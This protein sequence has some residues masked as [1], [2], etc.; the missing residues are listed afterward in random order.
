MTHTPS[1]LL[2]TAI[3]KGTKETKRGDGFLYDENSK[4]FC[5]LG[6]AAYFVGAV[7]CTETPEKKNIKLQKALDKYWSK[8]LGTLISIS[9]LPAGDKR[10]FVDY[11]SITTF[12]FLSRLIIIANDE[13]GWRRDRIG[14]LVKRLGF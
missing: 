9:D 5:S 4:G 1:I 12:V 6:A 14:N 8:E 3:L 2:S 13:L 7:D 11:V 10:F